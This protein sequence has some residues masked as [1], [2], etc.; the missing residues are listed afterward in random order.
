MGLVVRL[1]GVLLLLYFICC[2]MLDFWRNVT[3]QGLTVFREFGRMGEYYQPKI[4]KFESKVLEKIIL[5]GSLYFVLVK[6]V[7][8]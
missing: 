2:G 8:N 1:V 7:E 6:E 4:C 5:A 3:W